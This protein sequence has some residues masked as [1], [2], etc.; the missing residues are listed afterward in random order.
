MV[1]Q[2]TLLVADQE[3]PVDV[4]TLN[5]AEPPA[6][7][8]VRDVG[9]MAYEHCAVSCVTVKVCPAMV[10]VPVR[11]LVPVFTPT[12]R[13]TVPFP[14]P[15]KPLVTSI[16]VTLLTAVQEQ[17]AGAMTLTVVKPAPAGA[18]ALGGDSE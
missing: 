8:A 5:V 9:V 4:V 17:P 3:Q 13:P 11:G 18:V 6:A 1:I 12:L 15:L 14:A 7:V 10:A 2:A 16:H